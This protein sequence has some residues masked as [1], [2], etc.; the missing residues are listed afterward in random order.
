MFRLGLHVADR[1]QTGLLNLLRQSHRQRVFVC[2][3]AAQAVDT[4]RG[5]LFIIGTLT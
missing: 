3:F 5:H 1:S 2:S 4:G